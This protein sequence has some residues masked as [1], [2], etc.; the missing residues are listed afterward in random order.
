MSMDPGRENE[1]QADAGKSWHQYPKHLTVWPPARVVV[2]F[3]NLLAYVTS[4][5]SMSVNFTSTP[6]L[7]GMPNILSTN[8]MEAFRCKTMDSEILSKYSV[9]NEKYATNINSHCMRF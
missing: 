2:M 4:F 3:A 5:E 7:K 9:R 8:S 1:A 6:G